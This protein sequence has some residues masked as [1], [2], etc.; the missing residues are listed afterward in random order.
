M[1]LQEIPSITALLADPRLQGV[2]HEIAVEAARHTVALERE[3]IKKGGAP[4]AD[5]GARV[6]LEAEALLRPGLVPVIN[7]TG[8]PIHT[9]LGRAPLHPE[10]ARAVSVVARGYASVEMDLETGRRGGRLAGI[11]KS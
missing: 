4:T 11:D 1:S 5:L 3:R 10:A 9:N 6:A 8:I 2:P 7:A